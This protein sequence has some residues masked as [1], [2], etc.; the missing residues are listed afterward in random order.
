MRSDR[1]VDIL[2]WGA[3]SSVGRLVAQYLSR[4]AADGLTWGIG[5]RSRAKLEAL[6]FNVPIFTADA[7]DKHALESMV[8]QTKVVASTVGPYAIYGKELVDS[9]VRNGVS[10]CDITGEIF[11]IHEMIEKHHKRAQE[12]GSRI[13]HCC[14]FDSIPSDLGVLMMQNY[15]QCSE[16]KYLLTAA[17]GGLGGGT[18]ASVLHQFESAQDMKSRLVVLDPYSLS[19]NE[20]SEPNGLRD[21]AEAHFDN[22]FDSWVGP[23]AMASVNTRIVRRTNALAGYPYGKDFRYSEAVGFSKGFKGWAKSHALSAGIS[24]ALEGLKTKTGRMIAK[25]FAP[26]PG[27]GPTERVRN[28]GYFKIELLGKTVSGEMLRGSIC[29][30]SDPGHGETSKCWRK[31]RYA[32]PQRKGRVAF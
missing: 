9:C 23:F 32:L 30:Q 20:I 5:G 24:F 19:P 8:Q 7:S 12:T 10:Y 11:F 14:G 27:D 26:R 22:D 28:E 17:K 1:K 13:V 3:T 2:L 18:V 21:Y 6:G 16:I 29:G 15:R 25:K 31:A 4:R